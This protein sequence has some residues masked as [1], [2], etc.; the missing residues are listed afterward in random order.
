MQLQH[1][2]SNLWLQFCL[3]KA[4]SFDW[5]LKK[6]LNYPNLCKLLLWLERSESGI[7]GRTG[8]GAELIPTCRC[9]SFLRLSNNTKAGREENNQS[10]L[11]NYW[12]LNQMHPAVKD[13][14]KCPENSPKARD[15]VQHSFFYFDQFLLIFYFV[16]FRDQ[17]IKNNWRGILNF[18]IVIDPTSS[19]RRYSQFWWSRLTTKTRI[20]AHSRQTIPHFYRPLCP[21]FTS[22]VFSSIKE[23]Y[24]YL[25]AVLRG[26]GEGCGGFRSFWSREQ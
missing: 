12:R 20:S 7:G 10:T 21:M 9:L 6:L 4:C 1:L 22:L 3:E 23:Q 8:L 16:K 13:W 24:H 15:K 5:N 19:G 18:S 11:R 14:P 25:G 2:D 17:N 26:A